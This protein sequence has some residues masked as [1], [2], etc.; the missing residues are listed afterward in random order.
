MHSFVEDPQG[1]L[2]AYHMRSISETADSMDKRRFPW[3]LKKKRPAWRKD[4]ESFLRRDVHNVR[5]YSYLSYLEPGLIKKM[6][7]VPDYV[8]KP[9][10]H[11]CLNK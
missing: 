1:W 10:L 4:A 5:Q 3:K 11:D 7:R 9:N 6:E 2:R 8:P